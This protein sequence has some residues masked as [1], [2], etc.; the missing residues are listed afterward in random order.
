[1]SST[2]SSE[3]D[4]EAAFTTAAQRRAAAL[5]IGSADPLFGRRAEKLGALALRHAV[6]AIFQFASSLPPATW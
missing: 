2:P 3:R 1:M 6:P 4:F 5:V